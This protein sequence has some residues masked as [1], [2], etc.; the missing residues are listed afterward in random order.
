MLQ[1]YLKTAFRYLLRHRVFSGIN[2]FGLATGLSVCFFALLY[3]AFELSY[4][5]FH[6]RAGQIYRLVT[7]VET[8]A[9]ITYQSSSAPMASTLQ[10]TFPEVKAATR[11]FLDYLIVRSDQDNYKE[12][13]IAYADSTLFSVFTFPLIQG[14]PRSVLN[15]PWNVVLSETAAR[16]YFGADNPVGKTLLING[17]E[18]AY[19]T[20]IM[21]DIPYNSHFM[22]DI[23]VSMSSLI[24]KDSDWNDNWKRFGFYTYL[25]LTKDFLLLIAVAF[26]IAVPIAGITMNK[27][28]E[29]FAYRI[30]ISWWIFIA[31]GLASI[32]VA[33]ATISFIA[34]KAALANLVEAIKTE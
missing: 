6:E 29:E 8:S 32:L 19:V 26:V 24:S 1:N 25:L 34:V 33:F 21:K 13:H 2:L 4:D 15:A 22:V 20:G 14:D 18:P 11:I 23:L 10:T 28:L 31:A 27:W 7:D 12:E 5:R 16:K 17:G 9:G 3:V 30:N